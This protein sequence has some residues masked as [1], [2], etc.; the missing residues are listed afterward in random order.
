M[1]TFPTASA[2]MRSFH[3]SACAFL[4]YSAAS[5]RDLIHGPQTP[6]DL[7]AKLTPQREQSV[8]IGNMDNPRKECFWEL[9]GK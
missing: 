4:I 7:L 5:A 9:Y 1:A 3:R 2:G 8:I 6:R